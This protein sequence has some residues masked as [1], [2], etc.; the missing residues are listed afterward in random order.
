MYMYIAFISNCSH[1][2][3]HIC[4]SRM[5]LELCTHMHVCMTKNDMYAIYYAC[6]F[7]ISNATDDIIEGLEQ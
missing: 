4:R 3:M 5:S 7:T 2:C 6:S 1:P